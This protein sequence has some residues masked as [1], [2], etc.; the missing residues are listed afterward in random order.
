[1]ARRGWDVTAID[2]SSRATAAARRRAAAAR[3]P[4]VVRTGDV[5]DLRR[6]HGPF[7]LVLDI[8]CFHGLAPVAQARYA[9]HVIQ[10]TLP[11]A[12][13]LLYSFVDDGLAPRGGRALPTEESLRRL[14]TPAFAVTSIDHGTDRQRASAWF[15]FLRTG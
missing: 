7:D 3:L 10:R 14:F 6:V 13:Y 11:G 2:F 12:T 15:T 9:D 4:V 1:M 5:S 8:G